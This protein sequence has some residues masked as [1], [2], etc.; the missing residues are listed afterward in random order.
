[1]IILLNDK[2]N[3]NLNNLNHYLF[4]ICSNSSLRLLTQ[5]LLNYHNFY[6]CNAYTK[7]SGL[8]RERNYIYKQIILM[9]T[10]L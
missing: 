5:Y 4:G 10:L 1:M 9:Y 8:P 6:F 7:N 3:V 2:I